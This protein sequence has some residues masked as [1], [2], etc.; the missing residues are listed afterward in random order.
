MPTNLPMGYSA[1]Q[2]PLTQP[3][4]PLDEAQAGA[5]RNN[6]QELNIGRV[7]EA[8]IGAFVPGLGPAFDQ[9]QAWGAQLGST[10][11]G[12]N[13][14]IGQ[15]VDQILTALGLPTAGD[16]AAK[17]NDL[18]IGLGGFFNNFGSLV[19][20]LLHDPAAVLGHIGQ[21]MVTGLTD[22][23]N[24]VSNFITLI[25]DT[26]LGA[27]GLPSL[28]SLTDKIIDI[29]D[30]LGGWFED[31]GNLVYNLLHDPAAA[32]GTITHGM[33]DG[34]T[35]LFADFGD[36]VYKLL[37][38]PAAVLGEIGQD[39]VTGLEGALSGFVDSFTSIFT[40]GTN[41][42]T[43]PGFE[44]QTDSRFDTTVKR[45]GTRSLKLTTDSAG[46]GSYALNYDGT[47]QI[48]IKCSEGQK[49]YL[50]AWVQ[51][52]SD[53]TA[54]SG[55]Y[56]WIQIN[57][58]NPSGAY[59]TNVQSPR[60]AVD[61]VKD[62]NWHKISGYVTI[63]EGAFSFHPYLITDSGIQTGNQYWFDDCVIQEETAAQNIIETI[64]AGLGG[65]GAN[66]GAIGT[67]LTDFFGDFGSLVDNLLHDPAAVIGQIGA[68]L[69][70]GLTALA[71]IVFG[72]QGAGS[73]L[74]SD[75]GIDHPDLWA[76]GYALSAGVTLS[77]EQKHSTDRSLRMVSSGAY[78]S[79]FLNRN[80]T[81][82]AGIKVR[83][84]QK[85]YF[86]TYVY[87]HA[88]NTQVGSVYLYGQLT[89]SSGAHTSKGYVGVGAAANTLPKSQWNKI[90]GYIE[91]PADFN[92][93]F[94]D[95]FVQLNNDIPTDEV[96]Y[97]DDFILREV[98]ESRNILETIIGALGF[99]DFSLAG[100]TTALQ[101]IPQAVISGL[102]DALDYIRDRATDLF[103]FLFGADSLASKILGGIIPSLD[104]GIITTGQF[105][106]SFV[107]GLT[108]LFSLVFGGQTS[109]ANLL[110]DPGFE[111]PELWTDG[112]SLS[113]AALSTLQKHVGTRSLRLTGNS[114][115]AFTNRTG[116]SDGIAPI[117][118]Q[119][120][121][122]YYI[123]FWTYIPTGTTNTGGIYAYGRMVDTNGIRADDY[124]SVGYVFNGA[125]RDQWVKVSGYITVP[126]A[127][128]GNGYNRMDP[129]VQIGGVTS[130]TADIYVDDFIV[131]E[132]TE[133]RNII[134]TI[135]GALGFSTVSLAGLTTALQNI[136]QTVIS[137][138]TGAL[139]AFSTW[140]GTSWTSFSDFLYQLV[141]NP[142]A[143][144]GNFLGLNVF[145]SSA[146]AGSN[147]VIDP[148]YADLTIGHAFTN[149]FGSGV[150]ANP[151]GGHAGSANFGKLTADGGY[152]GA[153][154]LPVSAT[155]AVGISTDNAIKIKPG[156]KFYFEAWV[157]ADSGNT[158]TDR[159]TLQAYVKDATNTT[160]TYPQVGL[161]NIPAKGVWQ[162]I[163]GYLT[164]PAATTGPDYVPAYAWPVCQVD[165]GVP[166]G[167]IYYI[168]D[169]VF[170][171]VTES[172]N[173][174]ETIISAL[175]F[176]TF[177]F[178]GLTTALQNIPQTVIA[179][180]G[181]AL[182]YIRARAT[183]LF[184]FLF[185]VDSLASKILGGIIPS[186]DAGI[187]TTGQFAQTFVSGLTGALSNLF[188]FG[189][190]TTSSGVNLATDPDMSNAA[191]WI[192]NLDGNGTLS[193][194]NEQASSGTTSLKMVCAGNGQY[195]YCG[196]VL[197]D[198]Q[199]GGT[200]FL[201]V[202]PGQ[203]FIYQA[204]VK[205]K[206]SNAYPQDCYVDIAWI[207]SSGVLANAG[208]GGGS[209]NYH[210][211]SST[212][213]TTLKTPVS[214][215]PAGYD[216]AIFRMVAMNTSNGHT[217]VVGDAY[218]WDE[219]IIK[220]VTETQGIID[221]LAAGLGGVG[222]NLTAIAT[223]L[224]TF[225][226]NFGTLVNNL[227]TNPAAVIGT[228]TQGMV[229]GL[230]NLF[231]AFFLKTSA[232]PNLVIDPGFE[233][234]G[235]WV[236]PGSSANVSTTRKY[237]GTQSM[238]LTGIDAYFTPLANGT[239]STDWASYKLKAKSGQKFKFQ[240]K[241][242]RE[243][244]NS[245]SGS[246]YFGSYIKDAAGAEAYP[247][248]G[249]FVQSGIAAGVWSDISFVYSVPTAIG[250]GTAAIT[251]LALYI[252]I[253]SVSGSTN[254]GVGDI[255][256]IDQLSITEVTESTDVIANIISAL[257]F[258]PGLTPGL[259]DMVYA[260]NNI[261]TAI[262]HG[263]DS[264][265]SGLNSFVQDVIDN[266]IHALT[267]IPI[268][269]GAI[270][271]IFTNLGILKSKA[272][273]GVDD[274]AT[275]DGK[276]VKARSAITN[277]TAANMVI[278]PS[279]E[280]STLWTPGWG[281]TFSTA[282]KHSFTQSVKLTNPGGYTNMGLLKNGSGDRTPVQAGDVYEASIWV[283]RATGNS[284]S[285]YFNLQFEVS[286]SV[287]PGT[288]PTIYPGSSGAQ[289]FTIGAWTQLSF[290]YTIP[291]GYDRLWFYVQSDALTG[292]DTYYIDDPMLREISHAKAAQDTANTVNTGLTNTN[293]A[294]ANAWS[295]GSGA[296]GTSSEVTTAVANI[297]TTVS[298]GW[299]IQEIS[300]NG[301]WT[302]PT[303]TDKII[304]FWAICVGGGSGGGAGGTSF[305]GAPAQGVGG[306]GGKWAVWAI[307]P[308]D[309]TSS[310]GCSIGSGGAGV[311]AG[312]SSAQP[313]NG[314]ITSFGALAVS[315]SSVLQRSALRGLMIQRHAITDA[316]PAMPGNGGLGG[317]TSLG[318]ANGASSLFG[319]G[320]GGGGFGGPGGAGS[321][322]T[323][324]SM[325][326][327]LR[328]GGGGG[329]G[330]GG[331]TGQNGGKGGNGGYPGGGGGG[332]GGSNSSGGPVGGAGGNGAP[333]CI[334]LLYRLVTA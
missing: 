22:A 306:L 250:S 152:A 243:S 317:S 211:T 215:V 6:M 80:E 41:L 56:A 141:V 201:V 232:G 233:N 18:G 5:L 327:T 54:A 182:D 39:L 158:G 222:A 284:G 177:S 144:I 57:V 280:D 50:E 20:D 7:V 319:G 19:N 206:S 147:L 332:G 271:D 64:A 170:R 274:A 205:A 31:F 1:P 173:I 255:F 103:N 270:A 193:I 4:S 81:A 17:L 12:I 9:L 102:G 278:D 245:S 281:F 208:G 76:S 301:I 248:I 202:R 127:V 162:K 246:L 93:D 85:F 89:D 196:S 106:A 68:G 108:N 273:Q 192:T 164:I 305:P 242:W 330:G 86:E 227:L 167:N 268:I 146:S 97:F 151:T 159:L 333:G 325:T 88:D 237:N 238:K 67:A 183:D 299:T 113:N 11:D 308:A 8:L 126:A 129:F 225:F 136:P 104:A 148:S 43:N 33:V 186:L 168:D 180:L 84:G 135:V 217:S 219:P 249:N 189:S 261:P 198:P 35:G 24:N 286:S 133:S 334:V 74:L 165:P 71:S 139:S 110:P 153:F 137:G 91:I 161:F 59:F 111:R 269:G 25:V 99:G 258:T 77:T 329:G 73:N 185:G 72:G 223:A 303:T 295:G 275:A 160:F 58:N 291:T 181:S 169:V 266:I 26:I 112:G 14:W 27:L 210:T 37:H 100:L 253:P 69:V 66:L 63:P 62:G 45:T 289:G 316:T 174:L 263:L 157:A 178:A 128:S 155:T 132:V 331:S 30:E 290:T 82:V 51:G 109:G 34:L 96:Y 95:P 226:G 321:N 267:G 175:G 187:I 142:A 166:S 218:Y 15:L 244:G 87:P 264:T 282:Q 172:R 315:D 47:S 298:G 256:Y 320:G 220:E 28:G 78:D 29:G 150:I 3:E 13:A 276:A 53:N 42:V 92:W 194:S 60:V 143:V 224:G 265:L 239:G 214:E 61:S 324:V 294:V 134:E 118:V 235:I 307:D 138:L 52:K 199:L 55:K 228:I 236:G 16:L 300:T 312:G 234:S 2:V 123:E 107:G 257:G 98:T 70:D 191:Q 252:Q 328:S 279:F 149:A 171:E 131:R 130:G 188:G 209:E 309:I 213:W 212:A 105:A 75:P 311:S 48:P 116:N 200:L 288:Y 287:S 285:G 240:C 145:Q 293:K 163:S 326:G 176:S 304:E 230:T 32:I 314:G 247:G 310:V 322:G 313:G 79:A 38:D 49:Y 297:R 90:S 216:R 40:R 101:N 117:R 221:V 122:K 195:T 83:P 283:Q 179:G 197:R 296:A 23:L 44:K 272:Q 46:Q 156:D 302:R 140:I 124:P 65:V 121:E 204:K 229:S 119:S 241:A 207:D 120:G 251:D 21:D 231:N 10:L 115:Y 36:L 260:L 254:G 262:I 292:T 318:G 259:A 125:P 190:A 277:T 154:F 203:K 94:M 114:A 184:N 323:A